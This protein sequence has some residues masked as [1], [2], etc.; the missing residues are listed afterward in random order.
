MRLSLCVPGGK[1]TARMLKTLYAEIDAAPAPIVAKDAAKEPAEAKPTTTGPSR[2]HPAP[3]TFVS[4]TLLNRK[5]SAKQTWHLEFDL[6]GSGVEYVVG[7]AF[8]LFPTNDPG[9]VDAVL[10]A[11]NA[12]ADFPI[13]GR[14]LRDVLLD[15][16]SLSP[17]QRLGLLPPFAAGD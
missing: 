3:A 10:K 4:R 13:G 9:L 11:L 8:G 5:G 1:E 7:D 12:P 16:V 14:A 6:E 15:G 2:D 17:A